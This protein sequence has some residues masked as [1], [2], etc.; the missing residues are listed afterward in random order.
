MPIKTPRTKKEKKKA[1]ETVLKEH[2]AGTLKH[3]GTGKPVKRKDVALAIAMSESGQS[4]SKKKKP[5]KKK[6]IRGG[7]KPSSQKLRRSGRKK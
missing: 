1:V 7:K 5:A 2:K 6:R 3:G 4:K